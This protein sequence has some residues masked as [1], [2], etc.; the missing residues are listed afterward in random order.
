MAE[1]KIIKT[2]KICCSRPK[3]IILVTVL[4]LLIGGLFGGIVGGLGARY[5]TPWFETNILKIKQ[6]G[7]NGTEKLEIKEEES[8][9]ID[10]VKSVSPSVVSIIISKD[11]SKIQ[12]NSMN[13]PFGDF[14]NFGFPDSGSTAKPDTNSN[15]APQTQE[16]GGGTGF[17]ISEDGLILTNK[18][19]VSDTEADYTVIASDGTK[20]PAKVL[21]TDTVNDIGIVK[22]DAKGLKPVELGDSDKL[23]IG[24]TV[25]AIGNTLSEYRNTVTKGVVSGLSRRVT[26]GSSDGYSETIEEA[27]QTDAAINPG[28]SGG[29]LIDLA[30]QVIGVNTAVSQE[31]QL[32]GFAIPINIVKQAI[33]SVKTVG[34]IV[35]PFLGIRYVLITKD[36][37]DANNLKVDY[38]ALVLRG[39]NQTDLA[40]IPGSPA[41]KAGIVEND[42]VLEINGQ[43]IDQEHS[44]ANI[45]AKFKPGDVIELKILHK[46]EEKMVKV[47]LEE[48]K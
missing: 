32:I 4:S 43:K 1:E 10:A 45:V 28:N 35:R 38:G 22:I 36:I 14:F 20:Y 8:A 25:I 9:T 41:D 42:I 19:V 39:A 11:I 27:I 15:Q 13:F 47:K 44:L 12:N 48:R 18:H 16:I 26:A 17:I 40:V 29:P 23:Q 46:G 30:G 33:E 21:A 7:L 34:R 5:L 3:S 2:N 37:A 31:G 6:T 24:Q